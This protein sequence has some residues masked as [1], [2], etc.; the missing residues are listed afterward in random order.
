MWGKLNFTVDL[1]DE[2]RNNILMTRNTIPSW[3]IVV[4][5]SRK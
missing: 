4:L 5:L 3:S 2:K 1:F